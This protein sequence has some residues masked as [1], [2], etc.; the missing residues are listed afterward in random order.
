MR[1]GVSAHRMQQR[2]PELPC[3]NRVARSLFLCVVPSLAA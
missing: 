2:F 3:S 1:P